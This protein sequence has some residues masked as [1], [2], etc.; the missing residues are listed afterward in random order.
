MKSKTLTEALKKNKN[1]TL[2]GIT[3]ITDSKKDQFLSYKCLYDLALVR[4]FYFQNIVGLKPCD[5]LI[6]QIED[7]Q[8]FVVSFWACLLGGIIPIP[9]TFANNPE[10]INKLFNV[11]N[12][13]G[14]SKVIMPD[15]LLKKIEKHIH[16]QSAGLTVSFVQFEQCT[17]SLG[18]INEWEKNNFDKNGQPAKVAPDDLAFIQFSSGSTGE[19]KGVMLSHKNIITNIYDISHSAQ[20]NGCDNSLSWMPLTH[21]MGLIGL[22]LTPLVLQCNQYLMSTFLFAFY[23][24]TW[25][26]KAD[27]Y[28]ISVTS[29]P[30]FGYEH[31]INF[32]NDD[33]FEG[34]DLSWLRVILNG[35]EPI[36]YKVCQKFLNKLAPYNLKNNAILPVYGLAEGTLAI[37]NNPLGE[38]IKTHLIDRNSLTIGS[39]VRYLQE[40]SDKNSTLL[41]DVGQPV[42]KV[43]LEIRDEQ[44]VCLKEENIGLVF[45]K[46]QNVTRGYFNNSIATSDTI[47]KEGWLNTGDLGFLKDNRLTIIGRQKEI[48]FV[49]GQNYYANDIERVTH[50][51][52]GVE[53][54]KVGVC[55]VENLEN[56]C[57][58][59]FV[60]IQSKNSLENFALL[61]AEVKQIIAHQTGITVKSVVPIKKMPI[62]TSGKVQRFALKE[63][64]LKGE[65]DDTILQLKNIVPLAEVNDKQVTNWNNEFEQ[66][67]MKYWQKNAGH[68]LK[69]G[70]NDNFFDAGGNSLLISKVATDLKHEYHDK[71]QVS[72]FF[73]FSTIAKLAVELKRRMSDKSIVLKWIVLKEEL[74]NVNI[75]NPYVFNISINKE[76]LNFLLNDCYKLNELEQLILTNFAIAI[77][78]LTAQP[79]F[80]I[81]L[82][83]KELNAFLPCK[84]NLS[85]HNGFFQLMNT[86]KRLIEQSAPNDNDILENLATIQKFNHSN[87]VTFML[88]R[89]GYQKLHNNCIAGTFDCIL[90]Y[91]YNQ[92][93]NLQFSLSGTIKKAAVNGMV[94]TFASVFQKLMDHAKTPVQ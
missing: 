93:L 62:T 46:G 34:V 50:E 40:I 32:L 86:I 44:G 81:Y 85:Q 71:I 70:L 72:D 59:I 30:N 58:D 57:D 20:W 84:I 65:Y 45:I 23:P 68:N 94:N 7:N 14:H 83:T 78:T 4:L 12:I 21:D 35:A 15:K 41:V 38:L 47:S 80:T 43:K 51:V 5:K 92:N 55:G 67:I 66:V 69:I 89:Q 19:P 48:L 91:N 17:L 49:N 10:V 37:T 87:H 29:C 52:L 18:T 6:F 77:G 31:F 63:Y 64:Y 13:L 82:A 61:A 39:K 1:I 54:G 36:S 3:F 74:I 76:Q 25:M 27:E 22:H 26:R 60:F 42:G 79:E 28:K 11:W 33:D 75:K 53:S 56:G 2:K 16:G 73:A 9:L 24:L 8:E 88:T 90:S